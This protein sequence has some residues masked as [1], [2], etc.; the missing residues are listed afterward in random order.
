MPADTWRKVSALHRRFD[1]ILWLVSW[2]HY[3]GEAAGEKRPD[4]ARIGQGRPI[5]GSAVVIGIHD[6]AQSG[7]AFRQAFCIGVNKQD[8][9]IVQQELRQRAGVP[10][11]S[12]YDVINFS[13]L[14][15]ELLGIPVRYDMLPNAKLDEFALVISHLHQDVLESKQ[16]HGFVTIR[17][18]HQHISAIRK[19]SYKW[20]IREVVGLLESLHQGL[21][22]LRIALFVRQNL[23][24]THDA[25]SGRWH[26]Y[27]IR[28][29]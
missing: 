13:Q 5:Q 17:A 1:Y 29:H 22:S 9:S 19:L 24:D 10:T 25:Q 26:A 7:I 23:A 14:K 12:N 4:L 16:A 27:W 15:Q 20:R 21:R 18:I 6:L 2:E 8:W 28:K 3:Q 11:I